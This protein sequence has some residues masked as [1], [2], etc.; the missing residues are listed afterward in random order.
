MAF[1]DYRTLQGRFVEEFGAIGDAFPFS[2]MAFESELRNFSY[3]HG[4]DAQRNLTRRG[5]HQ[6]VLDGLARAI[7]PRIVGRKQ[8][9]VDLPGFGVLAGHLKGR[10][11]ELGYNDFTGRRVLRMP[12]QKLAR[13]LATSGSAYANMAR[14]I[15]ERGPEGFTADRAVLSTLERQLAG[16]YRRFRDFVARQDIRLVLASGDTLP[17]QR[18]LCR[19][20]TEIG[21]PYV[22]LA[23]GYIG[24]PALL[25]VA[26]VRADK[27][28]VW[29]ERQRDL[30]VDALPD[31]AADIVSVGFPNR[32]E[33]PD[34]SGVER[35]VLFAWEPL[36]YADLLQRHSPILE[37]LARR[38]RDAGFVP[39]FRAHPK[40][41]DAAW[42]RELIDRLDFERDKDT[43]QRALERAALVIS[44][45]ST[46]L[47]EV[48][49]VG[50]PAVQV[51]DIAR[52]DYE[53]AQKVPAAE[54]DPAA[55]ATDATVP[56]PFDLMD[57]DRVFDLLLGLVRTSDRNGSER[58]GQA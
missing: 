50:I 16:N 7:A 54:F 39:V 40:E 52:F 14:R 55:I 33:R 21:F 20:A 49:A 28:L 30:I 8:V 15:A 41:R 1:A 46:V 36:A 47:P 32:L 53:G 12:I 6:P 35:R 3:G 19:A 44:S 38:C 4:H 51:A 24:H 58:R 29:T 2:L 34:R 25:S 22:V 23:H 5:R 42:L 45:N 37:V 18:F 56:P 43:M 26:P 17:A 27:L 11:A 9:L 13:R 57:P 48:A 10:F 31:R